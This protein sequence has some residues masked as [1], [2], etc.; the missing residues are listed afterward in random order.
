MPPKLTPK[1]SVAKKTRFQPKRQENPAHDHVD[2]VEDEIYEVRKYQKRSVAEKTRFQPKRQ[3]TTDDIVDED[4][5]ETPLPLDLFHFPRGDT[6]KKNHP[7]S[8][9]YLTPLKI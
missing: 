2:E 3:K 7:V 6:I 5:E 4:E 8:S 1:R 9:L